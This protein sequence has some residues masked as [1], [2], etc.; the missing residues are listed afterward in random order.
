VLRGDLSL[1]FAGD[2]LGN[3]V[4]M[5]AL[6]EITA[7]V[8]SGIMSMPT[9]EFTTESDAA[10]GVLNPKLLLQPNNRPIKLLL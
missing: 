1:G 10:M 4:L 9:P 2:R 8:T 5:I 3:W 7:T 6:V